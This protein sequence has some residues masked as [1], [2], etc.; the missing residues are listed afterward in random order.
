M[1]PE[2]AY[3]F[4]ARRFPVSYLFLGKFQ[5]HQRWDPVWFTMVATWYRS[6]KTFLLSGSIT[7][8]GSGDWK[9]MVPSFC[10]YKHWCNCEYPLL[11]MKIWCMP[12]T[13]ISVMGVVPGTSGF[14]WLHVGHALGNPGS[15]KQGNLTVNTDS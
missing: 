11:K 14:L 15:L 7:L 3:I 2:L 5:L 4:Y 6:Q 10:V 8:W 13:C 1:F 12:S 9:S